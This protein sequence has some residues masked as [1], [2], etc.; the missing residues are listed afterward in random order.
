MNKREEVRALRSQGKTYAAI[1]EVTGLAKSTV[2]YYC[3]G[4]KAALEYQTNH[5]RKVKQFMDDFKAS[6]GCKNCPE[7]D[8]VCL[9]FHHR[10]RDVKEFTIGSMA[11]TNKYSIARVKREIA[12]CDVLC[13]NCHRKEEHRLLHT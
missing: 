2:S 6:V 9:D 1:M 10:D 8:P 11:I 5:R 3:R 12:K 13:A 4:G 7:K